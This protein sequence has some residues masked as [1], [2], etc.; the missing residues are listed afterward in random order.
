M[1]SEAATIAEALK[2]D[3]AGASLPLT[4]AVF[5]E[6]LSPIERSALTGAS[7]RISVFPY[8][9]EVGSISRAGTERLYTIGVAV[10]A[11]A[12]AS[13][14]STIDGLVELVE[15]LANRYRKQ[16]ISGCAPQLVEVGLGGDLY[17]VDRLGQ[18]MTFHSVLA[19]TYEKRS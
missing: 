7:P 12:V 5:R 14:T 18:A 3:I 15:T 8:Q 11:A 9:L 2:T 17:N 6:Y 10:R 19:I 1:P 13:A 4:V 16:A